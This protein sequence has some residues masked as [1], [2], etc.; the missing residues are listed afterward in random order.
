WNGDPVADRAGPYQAA[1]ALLG[2]RR[3][4]RSPRPAN[5]A[6][7]SAQVE[8]SGAAA[9]V[10]SAPLKRLLLCSSPP[11]RNDFANS[12]PSM[13]PPEVIFTRASGARIDAPHCPRLTVVASSKLNSASS[14][15]TLKWVLFGSVKLPMT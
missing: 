6:I 3:Q 8:G 2:A 1:A 4:P 5:P 12:E 9:I 10:G 11:P 15:S 7:S 13:L 14:W